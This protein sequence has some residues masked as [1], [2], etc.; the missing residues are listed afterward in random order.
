MLS[1]LSNAFIKASD[2]SL[3]PLLTGNVCQLHSRKPYFPYVPTCFDEVSAMWAVKSDIRITC[4][5]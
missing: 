4:R 2:C 5:D 1:G 3:A